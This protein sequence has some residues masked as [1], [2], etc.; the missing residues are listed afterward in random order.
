MATATNKPQASYAR[1]RRI[2]SE[3][4]A[5]GRVESTAYDRKSFWGK[6]KEY[7]KPRRIE[8]YLTN[9]DFDTII[10]KVSGF[11]G[12]VW[13][14]YLG[15]GH[16]VSTARVQTAVRAIGQTCEL[17][18]GVNPLYRA[19]EKYLRP[20]EHMFAGFRKSDKLPVPEIAI[21]VGVPDQMATVGMAPIAS[22]R[23]Q[24]VGDFGLIAFYYLLR[25]GE[26]T[27]RRKR[28]DTRTIQFRFQDVAFKR[29][30]VILPR[31]AS[32]ADLL[33]ATGATLRLSNQKNGSRGAMIHRSAMGGKFCPV[34]ALVRRFVHLRSNKASPDDIISSYW[35]HLGKGNL[36]DVDIRVA[37]KRAVITLKL[38][39]NGITAARVGTHSLRAGGAMALK[40]AGADRDDIK[41]MGRWSSDTWLIYIHDQIS[42]Y[43][44]G[45][46][47]KMAT[48]CSYFNLEGAFV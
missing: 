44:E 38:A 15:R 8:P 10:D 48:P 3:A 39:R 46:T 42:E 40:F 13:E 36:T 24:A 33:L 5:N 9:I 17:D 20:L 45:W 23:E 34:K 43:S 37:V 31:N 19:P 26:Y 32:L 2:A 11:A 6:W 1:D 27:H 18:R 12:R 28:H 30:N 22:P 16:Q 25:V 41:K 4:I 47:S 21:P 14:G 29:G 7:I 35:D